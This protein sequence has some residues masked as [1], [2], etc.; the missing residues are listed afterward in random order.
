MEGIRSSTRILCLA[1]LLAAAQAQL[2]NST[3]QPLRQLCTTS[4]SGCIL[5]WAKAA[6]V[7]FKDGEVQKQIAQLHDD[8]VM[9]LMTASVDP[10]DG[11]TTLITQTCTNTSSCE[12][13]T[14]PFTPDKAYTAKLCMYKGHADALLSDKQLVGTAQQQQQ[15]QQQQQSSTTASTT[16]AKQCMLQYL[17]KA[18]AD[19]GGQP[20]AKGSPALDG[21][22]RAILQEC[23]PASFTAVAA[24][25]EE[26]PAKIKDLLDSMLAYERLCMAPIPASAPAPAPG[27]NPT[28]LEAALQGVTDACARSFLQQLP[29]MRPVVTPAEGATCGVTEVRSLDNCCETL[30]EPLNVASKDLRGYLPK[31]FTMAPLGTVLFHNP[32]LCGNMSLWP[33]RAA[34]DASGFDAKYAGLPAAEAVLINYL[35]QNSRQLVLF[36]LYNTKVALDMRELSKNA[37]DYF[38]AVVL[39]HL[40]RGFLN[41]K[42]LV[43][44]PKSLDASSAV[45]WWPF[46]QQTKEGATQWVMACQLLHVS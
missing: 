33:S 9:C 3:L 39:Q 10:P 38:S 22:F 5:S 1:L 16:A 31:N 15:Q 30:K 29:E 25:R 40:G 7:L 32:Q 41:A 13:V 27:T 26:D 37:P 23:W 14:V 18:A 43:G 42:N 35:Q 11:S 34:L 20:L 2:S 28:S 19:S 36:G 44:I 6:G 24:S 12:Q 8:S 4:Y 21:A 46:N 45:A 17:Q